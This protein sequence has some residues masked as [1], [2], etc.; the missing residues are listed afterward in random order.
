MEEIDLNIHSLS[1]LASKTC[2]DIMKGYSTAT[3]EEK[4][5][6]LDKNAASIE[7]VLKA[8]KSFKESKEYLILLYKKKLEELAED[9]NN[10]FAMETM[11]S[12]STQQKQTLLNSGR[13]IHKERRESEQKLEI[14]NGELT[15]L[16]ELETILRG[17]YKRTY[18]TIT[19][20]VSKD[21]KLKKC[22]SY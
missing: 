16:A 9:A 5:K 8:C 3:D 6:I 19:E 14:L 22:L 10:L 17:S 21:E 20:L 7:T 1:A 12:L 15:R 18:T 11:E 2:N 4:M 13:R